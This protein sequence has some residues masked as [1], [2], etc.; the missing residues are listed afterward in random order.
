MFFCRKL[1][2]FA[3]FYY[4]HSS[5][6][7]GKK[8]RIQDKQPCTIGPISTTLSTTLSANDTTA[9]SVK[10]DYYSLTS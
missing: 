2:N 4:L 3:I 1:Y 5:K 9:Y 10:F 6:A 7:I 8:I